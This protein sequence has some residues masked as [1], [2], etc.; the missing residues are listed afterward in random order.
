MHEP[1]PHEQ[2]RHRGTENYP[3]LLTEIVCPHAGSEIFLGGS[4]RHANELARDDDADGSAH[5]D[6]EEGLPDGAIKVPGEEEQ[7]RR[8]DA[9]HAGDDA[10]L[11]VTFGSAKLVRAPL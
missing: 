6:D 2:W 3:Q 8:D 7:G 5:G 11:L 1:R 9:D 4:S 10:H